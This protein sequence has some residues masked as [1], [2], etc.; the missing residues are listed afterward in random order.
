MSDRAFIVD[1]SRAEHVF[2]LKPTPLEDVLSAVVR[3]A[4]VPA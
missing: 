3:E 1:S 2:G 4:S